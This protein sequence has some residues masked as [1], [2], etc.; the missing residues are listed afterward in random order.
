MGPQ[1]RRVAPG[2]EPIKEKRRP[3]QVHRV[4]GVMNPKLRAHEVGP[5][6]HGGGDVRPQTNGLK[7]RKEPPG[8]RGLRV[9]TLAG[10]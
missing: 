6:V 2:N 5:Q 3:P 9:K 4:A 1:V 7:E 10:V 8:P